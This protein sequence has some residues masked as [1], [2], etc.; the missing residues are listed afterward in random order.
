MLIIVFLVT[1][2]VISITNLYNLMPDLN[3]KSIDSGLIILYAHVQIVLPDSEAE[4]TNGQ[5]LHN[6]EIVST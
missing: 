1:L 4:L 3:N 2:L 5:S 6:A